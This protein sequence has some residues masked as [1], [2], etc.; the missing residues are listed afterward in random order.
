MELTAL[1]LR[2]HAL[3]AL[4]GLQQHPLVRACT[5]TMDYLD[6]ANAECFA[7]AY[8]ALCAAHYAYHDASQ[9]LLDAVHYDVNTLTDT[10]AAPASALLDAA[11]L[12]IEAL[13]ALL[14]IDGKA[15]KTPQPDVIMR[16][17]C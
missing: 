14:A 7:D 13:N 15:L 9:A 3:S 16:P 8:G 12:D 11:T 6:G 1:S 5:Q 10:L 2:L 4:R 17:R